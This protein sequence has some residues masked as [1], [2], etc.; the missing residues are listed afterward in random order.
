MLRITPGR[1]RVLEILKLEEPTSAAQLAERLHLTEA[2]VRQHLN[3]LEADGLVAA[4]TTSPG[5]PG[6][7]AAR[8][9]LTDDGRA[10]F[11]DRHGELTVQLVEAMRS[12]LGEEGLA[13]VIDA[14]TDDQSTTYRAVLAD[15]GPRLGDRVAALARQRSAEGYIAEVV[16]ADGAYVLVEHHCP[17]C[18]AARSCLGFCSAELRLFRE[19][20]GDDARVERTEHLLSDGLRCS[21]RIEP[22]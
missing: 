12:T 20:L 2:A 7:P 11:P 6:R 21:Y 14:R 1:Q 8:W 4:A 17:I 9:S 15:A 13:R 18:E 5:T 19:A 10:L 22:R 16:A 3:V